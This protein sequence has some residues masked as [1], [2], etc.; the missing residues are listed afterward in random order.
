MNNIEDT[1]RVGRE[2]KEIILIG[3]HHEDDKR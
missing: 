3:L 1:V 2:S